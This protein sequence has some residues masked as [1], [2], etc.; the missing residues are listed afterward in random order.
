MLKEIGS[1]LWA[2]AVTCAVLALA[3]WFTRHVVG[4]TAVGRSRQGRL[5]VLEQ[6]SLGREQ[7]L[8]LARVGDT[9]YLL[10]VTQGGITCL[11]VLSEE[12]AGPF[13]RRDGDGAAPGSR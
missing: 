9:V 4:R 7:R 12:E 13:L 8:V 1:L 2:L 6:I 3:Y 5:A 11:R 10:G